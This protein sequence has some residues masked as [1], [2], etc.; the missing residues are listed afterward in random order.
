M[1]RL[2]VITT[3][4]I[5]YYAPIFR[6][7]TERGKIQVKVFYTWEQ[8]KEKVYDVNFKRE[9][10]WDI[11]LLDGYEYKFVKN[12]AKQPGSHHFKGIDNPTLIEEVKAYH[13][14]ALYII[15]WAFKGHLRALRFFKGRLPVLFR[16]DSTILNEQSMIKSFLRKQFLTWVYRHVDKAMYVGQRNRA[17]YLS[18]GMKEDQLF[19]APHAVENSRFS[20]LE[21]SDDVDFRERLGI[22]HNEIVVL[23]AGKLEPRKNPSLLVNTF[24]KMNIRHMHLVIVGN[25]EL[26]EEIKST[27]SGFE[28]V[29]FLDFQNQKSMPSVYRLADVFALPSRSETWGLAINEAMACRKAVLVSD[30]CGCAVDLVEEGINGFTFQSENEEELINKLVLISKRS[31]E[32]L[33][34][35][36]ENSYTKIQPWSFENICISIETTLIENA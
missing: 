13:P 14:D 15:G 29:H 7:L 30:K 2:A 36:G 31:K 25:G 10:K 11:P 3:H 19:F 1:K 34:T 16:G 23:F 28:N 5:Q 26:E 9:V 17:Y 12:V 33:K 8:S 21:D 22:S 35:M 18:F 20:S 4:P 27:C 32:E 24:K 6:M